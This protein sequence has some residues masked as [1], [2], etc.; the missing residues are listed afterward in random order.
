MNWSL[1]RRDIEGELVRVGDEPPHPCKRLP[2][3]VAWQMFDPQDLEAAVAGLV[4]SVETDDEGPAYVIHYRGEVSPLDLPRLRELLRPEG[5]FA[6]WRAAELAHALCGDLRALH[7]EGLPQLLVHPERVGLAAGRFALLPTYAG[8]LPPLPDAPANAVAGWMHFIAPE[9]LRTRGVDKELMFAGDLY[10]LGRTLEAACLPN[11][12]PDAETELLEL[13][14]SRVES[15]ESSSL[16]ELPPPVAPLRGLLDRMTALL[17]H[18]RPGLESVVTELARLRDEAD[19]EACVRGLLAGGRLSEAEACLPEL[20]EM[21]GAGVYGAWRRTA[22]ILAADIALAK[23]PPDC[24]R[25]I[26]ELGRA[27]S[28]GFYELD[29][30]RRLG[31][32]YALFTAQSDHLQRSCEAYE[33]AAALSGWDAGVLD[34]WVA[35][36][37]Q[38]GEPEAALKATQAVPA[39]K[40]TL[41]IFL[42]RAHS[43]EQRGAYLYAWHEIAAGLGLVCFDPSLYEQA[44]RIASRNDPLDLVRWMTPYRDRPDFAAP[45]SLV[46]EM[47]GN[48]ELARLKL[49]EAQNYTPP[50]ED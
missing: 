1:I 25:A 31:R 8:V 3:G 48:L 5:R 47:N 22:H 7:D 29:V 11:W 42:L 41:G 19:P 33:R 46:W 21:G 9:V 35:V 27:E 10:S 14:E 17:P 15:P 23:S 26:V 37:W 40:R 4:S 44:R 32:A 6:L 28:P 13:A 38:S 16:G 34:E 43:W 45:E 36:L 20:E 2:T 50:A 18:E 12:L 49:A 30:Q 24:P 39:E